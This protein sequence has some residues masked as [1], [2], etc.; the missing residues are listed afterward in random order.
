MLED[1]AGDREARSLRQQRLPYWV[2]LAVAFAALAY[3][4]NYLVDGEQPDDLLY[5]WSTAVGGLVQYAIM[6]G[7]LFAIARGIPAGTLGLRRPSSWPTAL[8]LSV[9]VLV[10]TFV[11]SALYGVATRLDAGEEQGLLPDG[12][13]GSRWA[14]LLA[15]ALMVCVV[16]PV[17][18]E[19]MYRGVGF[20]VLGSVLTRWP[21]I[22]AVGLMFGLAHGLLIAL[23]V[24]AFFGVALAW[25][26]DRTQSLVPPILTHAVFNTLA[27]VA[28]L[29]MGG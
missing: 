27:L 6:G 19:F 23:P 28:S 1:N 16:A 24:L 20:S 10:T 15:N 11:A 29:T 3:A 22:L 26:R 2:A 13:D 5:R 14:P 18:E 21:T 7:L 9:A 12:W 25:L 17:V 4:G 8:G